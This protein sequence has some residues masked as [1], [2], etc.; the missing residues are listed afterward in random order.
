LADADRGMRRPLASA[1]PNAF[2]LVVLDLLLGDSM[3]ASDS[4]FASCSNRS[5]GQCLTIVITATKW[6][7]TIACRCGRCVAREAVPASTRCWSW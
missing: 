6:P 2:A 5:G 1:A 7:M 4:A 3:A